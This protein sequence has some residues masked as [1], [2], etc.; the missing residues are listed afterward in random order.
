[1]IDWNQLSQNSCP[2]PANT[3]T[4]LLESA[5]TGDSPPPISSDAQTGLLSDYV[6]ITAEGP[7]AEKFLNGQCTSVFSEELTRTYSFGAH[8]NPQGRMESLFLAVKITS[9]KFALRIKRDIA[10][11]ALAQLKKYAVFSKVEINLANEYAIVYTNDIKSLQRALPELVDNVNFDDSAALPAKSVMSVSNELVVLKHGDQ[12][13]E[14]WTS[15]LGKLPVENH[16]FDTSCLWQLFCYQNGIC[17]LTPESLGQ[18]LP[19]EIHLPELGGVSFTKGCYTG[20][21]VISRLHYKGNLKKHLVRIDIRSGQ[22]IKPTQ[23]L[24]LENKNAGLLINILHVGNN[25]YI[26]LAQIKD[27]ALT[28]VWEGHDDEINR[29]PAMTMRNAKQLALNENS[30]AII[31]VSAALYAIT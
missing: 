16:L 17:E 31:Q 15:D 26:G 5:S 1:M 18:L 12:Q 6:L 2:L 13:I 10:T 23:K 3:L 24:L 11:H 8:C 27:T 7:D 29:P 22:L 25:H 20:Q 28:H 19:Q 21:E 14:V 30:A 9:T 4:E